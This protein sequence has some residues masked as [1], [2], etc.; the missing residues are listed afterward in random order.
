MKVPFFR[1]K[2]GDSEKREILEVLKSGWVTSGP[3]VK[4]FEKQISRIA[5]VKYAAAVSSGTAGLH[6]ALEAAEAGKGD[7][8]ITSPFT[9]AAT[10][11][12]ILYAG[13]KPVFVDIDPVSLNIDP[14]LIEKKINKK[15]KA[16]VSVDIAGFPCDYSRLTRIAK[17]HNLFLLDDAAHSLGATYRGKPIGSIADAVVFSFYSTKNITTGE[18]GMVVSK[19]RQLIE[20]VRH[21]S[22]HG[23]TSSGWKRYSGGGWEYDITTLGYKYNMPDL[24]AAL[25]L[26]QLS[27]FKQLQDKRARLADRYLEG[28]RGLNE[29]IELPTAPDNISHGRH[30]FI[31]K[32]IPRRWKI[33]R[34]RLITELEKK[35]VGCGVHFIP[36]YRFS[37]FKR[38]MSQKQREFPRTEEAFGRVISLPFYPDLSFGEADYVCS[39][40]KQMARRYAR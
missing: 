37:Y 8:V 27:H 29:L 13:A 38:I 2:F 12:A 7:E 1:L 19:S 28:L 10:V 39:A 35:G 11:E 5:G 21:L 17:A 4:Q 23:M 31:I 32:I 6:L 14:A 30:L 34:D 15:T 16:I 25:G 33:N 3:K 40:I 24:S 18:G 20:T 9:M 36:I 22:L 26:G